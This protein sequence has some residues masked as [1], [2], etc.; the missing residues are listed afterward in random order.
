M[1]SCTFLSRPRHSQQQIAAAQANAAASTAHALQTE[2]AA[3]HSARVAV[4]LRAELSEAR[5][6]ADIEVAQMREAHAQ[7]AAELDK[8]RA[9]TEP[10][11]VAL[12]A[13]NTTSDCTHFDPCLIQFSILSGTW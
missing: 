9:E 5:R 13:M 3:A 2:A 8:C 4:D 10:L 1:N 11:R 6:A 12:R 7:L